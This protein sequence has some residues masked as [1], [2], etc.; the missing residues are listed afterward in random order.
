MG[1]VFFYKLGIYFL[2]NHNLKRFVTHSGVMVNL[3][4]ILCCFYFE[5]NLSEIVNLFEFKIFSYICN[6]RKGH[7][8]KDILKF[9]NFKKLL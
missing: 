5:F 8:L 7:D 4:R 6:L 9:R 1:F 2:K 3:I